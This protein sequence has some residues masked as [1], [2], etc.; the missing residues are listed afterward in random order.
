MFLLSRLHR[1]FGHQAQYDYNSKTALVCCRDPSRT[2]L[3]FSWDSCDEK[4]MQATFG[5]G[6]SLFGN[7]LDLQ[8]VGEQLGYHNAGLDK[9][10]RQILGCTGYKSKQVSTLLKIVQY[11]P[12]FSSIFH[13]LILC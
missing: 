3:G 9:L 10:T 4:K 2:I 7:F 5:M 11:L 1:F 12:A 6:K 8:S 13:G